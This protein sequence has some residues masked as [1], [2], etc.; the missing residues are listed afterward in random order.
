MKK[1]VCAPSG[2]GMSEEAW[3]LAEDTG[4]AWVGND[5]AAHITLLRSTVEQELAFGMEQMGV[6]VPDMRARIQD[7]AGQWGL[8]TLLQRDPSKLSTGQTRRVAIASA[9]LRNPDNLVLDCPLD[10]C[11]MDA[12]RA[13]VQVVNSFPGDVTIFDRTW[14]HLADLCDVESRYPED[15]GLNPVAGANYDSPVDLGQTSDAESPPVPSPALMINDLVVERHAFTLGPLSAE[16]PR[17]ITHIAGPNGTGKTTLL[18]AL[19]DLIEHRGGSQQFVGSP[20]PLHYGWAPTSMDTSFSAK[21]VRD[22]IAIGSTLRNADALIEYC[23]LQDVA[24]VHPL[25]VA[26]SARRI[27]SVACALARGPEFL[28][29]DEPTVG[30]DVYGYRTVERIMRGFVAGEIH[31]VLRAHGGSTLGEP[32]SVV[33]TCHNGPYSQLSDYRLV[34]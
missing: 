21:T 8:T 10:G 2:S 23:G 32:K 16:I 26:S 6:P 9:L 5:A 22:E 11:D 14:N 19:A 28:F 15:V 24:G 30:L 34:L 3:T 27:V 13:L 18:L 4:A 25:D 29:L 1:F 20:H 17:G 31:D 7:I 12:T 33:W